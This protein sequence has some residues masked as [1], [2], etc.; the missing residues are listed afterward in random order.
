MKR[1]TLTISLTFLSFAYASSQDATT[2]EDVSWDDFVDMIDESDSDGASLD[3]DC[4]DELYAIHANPYDINEV[5]ADELRELPFLSAEQAEGI[6]EYVKRYGPVESLGELMMIDCLTERERRMLRLFLT[7]GIKKDAFAPKLSVLKQGTHEVLWRTD[8]PLYCKKGFKRVSMEELKKNPNKVYAGDRYKHA[9]RY[10]F[11]VGEHLKVGAMMEKDAGEIGVDHKAGYVMV[12]NMGVVKNAVVGSFR[13]SYG[14]GLAVNTSASFGKGMMLAGMGKLDM[15]VNKYSGMGEWGYFNGGAVTLRR[16]KWELSAYGSLRNADGTFRND[17][18]GITAFKTDGLHRTK[19]ERSKKGNV[20]VTDMGAN[21]HWGRGN[22]MVSASMAI[23]HLDVA[24]L[25]SY[26]TKASF[27]RK[28][29]ARGKDFAVGSISYLWRIRRV[30]LSGENAFSSTQYQNGTAWIGCAQWD[31]DGNNVFSLIGR[32]YGAKFVSMNGKAFGENANVQNEEG[33]YASWYTRMIKNLQ[34]TVYA[35]FMYFPWLKYGVSNSSYACECAMQATYTKSKS[36]SISFRYKMKAKQKDF[37]IANNGGGKASGS[38]ADGEK[39]MTATALGWRT[40][41]NA[42]M[43]LLHS[44]SP[45]WTLR[46]NAAAVVNTSNAASAE[47]GFAFGG[48]MRWKKPK[49]KAWVDMGAVAFFTDSYN[50]RVYAYE[51]SLPYSFGF[52]SFFYKGMRTTL[53]ASMPLVKGHLTLN[54]KIGS[55]IYF[56]RTAIGSGLDMIDATHKE[57]VQMQIKWTF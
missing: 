40:T 25:P 38:N 21:L 29:Q 18:T 16:G 3:A 24:L 28:Y 57:D 17:S 19:L 43:T 55:T 1:L 33:V 26:D 52:S 48:N 42:K 44:F 49:G 20:H 36:T 6:A 4:M 46:A 53:A 47:T 41:H 37:K 15:G 34:L 8:A 31:A 54:T 22:V 30:T 32:Y 13:V 23:T 9:M 10:A 12:K 50:A 5:T 11:N 2:H 45:T 27:Y 7:A 39:G 56:D 51:A 14:M 35:D